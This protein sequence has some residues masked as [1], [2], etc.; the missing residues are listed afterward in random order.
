MRR[1]VFKGT[2]AGQGTRLASLNI[3]LGQAGRIEAALW[4]LQQGNVDVSFLQEMNMTKGIHTRHGVGYDVWETETESRHQVGVSVV[5][6][7]EKGWQVEGT[8][9]FGP[10]VVIFLLTLGARKWYFVGAY[11]PPKNVSAVHRVEQALR[12]APNGLEIILIGDLNV[13]LR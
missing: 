7:D 8:V 6:R 3:R 2:G 4:A 5:C 9:N 11:M 12:A 10:S 1:R 13:R